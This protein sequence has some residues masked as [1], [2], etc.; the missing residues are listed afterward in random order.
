[1]GGRKDCRALGPPLG[2]DGV[3]QGKS[4]WGKVWGEGV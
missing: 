3:S 4:G 1:M 2:W